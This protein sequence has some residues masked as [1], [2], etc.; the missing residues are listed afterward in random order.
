MTELL[1]QYHPLLIETVA[2]RAEQLAYFVSLFL[3]PI[4]KKLQLEGLA[5]AQLRWPAGYLLELGAIGQ[6]T[7]WELQG[8]CPYLPADLPTAQEAMLQLHERATHSPED[9]QSPSNAHLARRVLQ[10][11]VEQECWRGPELLD[12]HF[13]LTSLEGDDEFIEAA[14][15]LLWRLR[16]HDR[17]QQDE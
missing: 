3:E 11:H 14:A 5:S 2:S 1:E 13:A 9:L 10:V 12:A 8:L 7:L 4:R 15:Q 17:Q 6:L 16:H